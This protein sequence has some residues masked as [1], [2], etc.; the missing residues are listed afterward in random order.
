[1]RERGRVVG[2]SCSQILTKAGYKPALRDTTNLNIW[3]LRKQRR[4]TEK[5]LI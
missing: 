1:M 2:A 5:R 3:M 4:G